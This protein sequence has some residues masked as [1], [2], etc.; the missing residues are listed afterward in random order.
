MLRKAL[1]A[2]ALLALL[3]LLLVFLPDGTAG[4]ASQ[5]QDAARY[6]AT[7]ST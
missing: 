4:A 7:D 2:L 1:Y 5:P 6:V 3:I